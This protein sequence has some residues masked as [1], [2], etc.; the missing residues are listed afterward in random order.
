MYKNKSQAY[1]RKLII[2]PLLALNFEI[3]RNG[4]LG[5]NI[6]DRVKSRA[7]ILSVHLYHDDESFFEIQPLMKGAYL[8]S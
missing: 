5:Q 4:Y 8:C 6:R 7:N 3:E 1:D 2:N